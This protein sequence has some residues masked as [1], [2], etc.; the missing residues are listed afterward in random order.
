MPLTVTGSNRVLDAMSGRQ[1]WP[2][3]MY[4]ALCLDQ[5]AG[6]YVTGD[7]LDEPTDPAYQ[8]LAVAWDAATWA[9]AADG[10]HANAA[11]LEWPTAPTVVWGYVRFFALCYAPTSGDVHGWDVLRASRMIGLGPP[12]RFAIGDLRPSIA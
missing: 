12:P 6:I 10:M 4:L 2:A 3:T 7:D 11:V 8:R 1:A 5:P 9:A